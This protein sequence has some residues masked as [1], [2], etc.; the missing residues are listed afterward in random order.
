[1]VQ[2]KIRKLMLK[3]LLIWFESK[4]KLNFPDSASSTGG[5]GIDDTSSTT[6]TTNTAAASNNIGPQLQGIVSQLA[7]DIDSIKDT[8]D[9]LAKTNADTKINSGSKKYK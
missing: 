2:Y 4:Q 5:G 6:A 3:Y 8:I 1:M 7:N 9:T